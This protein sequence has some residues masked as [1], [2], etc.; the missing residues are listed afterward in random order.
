[1]ECIMEVASNVRKLRL[2]GEAH[3]FFLDLHPETLIADRVGCFQPLHH[4]H[5]APWSP[6]QAMQPSGPTIEWLAAVSHSVWAAQEHHWQAW[7][8]LPVDVMAVPQLRCPQVT[9]Q[10]LGVILQY[11]VLHDQLLPYVPQQERLMPPCLPRWAGSVFCCRVCCCPYPE[12]SAHLCS[13]SI[14]QWYAHQ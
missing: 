7:V 5:Y 9:E 8:S 10:P 13:K 12:Q 11:A 4:A 3:R 14:G 6:E 2:L 1:M